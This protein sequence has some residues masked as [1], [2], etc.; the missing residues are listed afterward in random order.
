MSKY[1][2]Y[3]EHPRDFSA[4]RQRIAER[5]TYEYEFAAELGMNKQTFS[6]KLNNITP[7]SVSEICKIC[8]LLKIPDNEIEKYF[9]T[10]LIKKKDPEGIR[11][12]IKSKF[13]YEAS[14]ARRM[15]MSKAA[16]CSRL[17]FKSDFRYSELMLLT[18]A[19][20][21]SLDQVIALIEIERRKSNEKSN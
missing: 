4:I 2:C 14:L 21:I 11:S 18:E 20:E 7:F 19:L 5:Y 15:G 17:N 3:Y 8:D 9:R 16:L 13:K 12:V 6:R 1:R 10:L